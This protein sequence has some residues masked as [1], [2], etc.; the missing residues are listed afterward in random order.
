MVMVSRESLV[1][2]TG[3]VNQDAGASE[4]PSRVPACDLPVLCPELGS[5]KSNHHARLTGIL[6]D[7]FFSLGHVSPSPWGGKKKFVCPALVLV[8]RHASVTTGGQLAPVRSRT[9]T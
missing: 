7:A 6:F 9:C 8:S 1:M 3:E 4:W 2:V 5:S